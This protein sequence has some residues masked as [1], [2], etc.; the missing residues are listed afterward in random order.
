MFPYQ[1][2]VVE[3]VASPVELGVLVQH[4]QLLLLPVHCS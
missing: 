3:V 4:L 2:V 1:E